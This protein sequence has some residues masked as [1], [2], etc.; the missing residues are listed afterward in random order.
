MKKTALLAVSILLLAGARLEASS[1]LAGD[2]AAI[3]TGIERAIIRFTA[4]YDNL[5]GGTFTCT[6][7]RISNRALTSD[8]EDCTLTDLS[9]WPQGTYIGNPNYNVNG[10]FYTWTSDY[11]AATAHHVRIIITD[12]GDGT[13]HA[14]VEAFY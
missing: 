6:G 5:I 9:T 3:D 11:D 14:D 12:N 2:S 7:V 8:R 10:T 1:S 13:G 4:T